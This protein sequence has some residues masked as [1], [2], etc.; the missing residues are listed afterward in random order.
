MVIICDK[1]APA[2]EA[3]YEHA[4][5]V[6]IGKAERAVHL[7]AALFARP[8]FHGGEQRGGHVRVVD[9]INLRKAHPMRAEF[10][11][12]LVTENRADP[13]DDFPVPVGE[14]RLGLAVGKGGIFPR[15]PVGEVVAVK[16]GNEIGVAPVKLVGIVHEPAKLRFR[17]DLFNGDGAGRCAANLRGDSSSADRPQSANSSL[18]YT[19][20]LQNSIPIPIAFSSQFS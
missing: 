19:C 20:F 9:E 11:V 2:V 18:S 5:A 6:E 17:H 16:R 7:R 4:L 1:Q 10:F 12:G 14:K 8:A 3:L 15:R 13:S